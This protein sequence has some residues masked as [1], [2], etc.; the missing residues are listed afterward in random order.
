M[1]KYLQSSVGKLQQTCKVVR[2]S[3][4]F[5]PRMFELLKGTSK[6]QHFIRLN[7]S[8]CSD[9]MWW[10]FFLASWNGV[11]MLEDPAWKSA[12]FHLHTDASGS[13]GCGAWWGHSWFQ[14]FW[15]NCFKQQSIAVKELLP[16]V[17]AC[18]EC[19]KTLSKNAVIVHCDN[20]I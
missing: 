11:S 9:F 18:M 15:P 5:L 16:I 8:F 12:P 10:N 14:Y 13:F 3:Q 4:T 6:K 19:G 7:A 20:N 1:K 2:S 17:M